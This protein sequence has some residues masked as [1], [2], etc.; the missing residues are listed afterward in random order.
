MKPK[1]QCP[2]C[3]STDT[4]YDEIEAKSDIVIFNWCC[5]KCPCWWNSEYT[6]SRRYIVEHEFDEDFECGDDL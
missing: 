1:E 3:G 5:Y 6:F 2:T 4:G